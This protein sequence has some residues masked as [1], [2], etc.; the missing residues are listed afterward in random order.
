MSKL[1]KKPAAYKRG[2]PTLQNMKFKKIS[3]FCGSFLPSWIRIRIRILN[4]DPDPAPLARL[5]PDPIRIRI[6][7]P[8]LQYPSPYTLCHSPSQPYPYLLAPH[9]SIVSVQCT[10][11]CTPLPTY[12]HTLFGTLSPHLF[13][14]PSDTPLPTLSIF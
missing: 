10:P 2:H 4:P 6:R 5:N 1:Q 13:R 8:A 9:L 7:N 12:L 14:R 11:S 3:Y